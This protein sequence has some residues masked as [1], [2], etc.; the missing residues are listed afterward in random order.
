MKN[1]RSCADCIHVKR[2]KEKHR[3]SCEHPV[4]KKSFGG[5]LEYGDIQS[6]CYVATA[7]RFY[8]YIKNNPL[9]IAQNKEEAEEKKIEELDKKLR[10]LDP[11]QRLYPNY[12]RD[13]Y[14][15]GDR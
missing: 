5:H 11:E 4:I 14:S 13:T 1:D 12:Y 8:K 7:C 15:Q 3:W 10:Q 2:M 6:F 9:H